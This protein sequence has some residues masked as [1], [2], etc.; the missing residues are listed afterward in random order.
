V[1]AN[2]REAQESGQEE[3]AGGLNDLADYIHGVI[4]P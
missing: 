4:N 3:L 2:A 1:E